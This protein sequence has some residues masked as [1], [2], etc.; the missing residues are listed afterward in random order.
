MPWALALARKARE[1]FKART[2]AQG[3]RITTLAGGQEARAGW[4][5]KVAE[6]AVE[7][8]SLMLSLSQKQHW[9]ELPLL[10]TLS[11]VFAFWGVTKSIPLSHPEL[12]SQSNKGLNQEVVDHPSDSGSEYK[13]D[14]RSRHNSLHFPTSE[15]LNQGRKIVESAEMTD[16]S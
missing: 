2:V 12:W 14:E 10:V 3:R 7:C 16:C 6:G 1:H 11:P 4:R 9:P 13:V 8:S 15:D 5:P